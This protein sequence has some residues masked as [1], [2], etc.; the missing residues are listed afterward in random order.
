MHET[1]CVKVALDTY[2]RLGIADGGRI[3]GH[4]E[5][6]IEDAPRRCNRWLR[7]RGGF[8]VLQ[9]HDLT[10]PGDRSSGS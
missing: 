8:F 9:R 2:L 10:L 1:D 5:L 4:M 3:P 6:E 7:E